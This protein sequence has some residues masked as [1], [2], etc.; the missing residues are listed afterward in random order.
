VGIASKVVMSYLSKVEEMSLTVSTLE[1][2][3]DYA[4]LIELMAIKLILHEGVHSLEQHEQRQGEV[5][6]GTGQ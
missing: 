3:N 4:G 5:Y 6:R 1:G 2:T